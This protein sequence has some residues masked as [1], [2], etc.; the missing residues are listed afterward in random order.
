MSH[1]DGC[2]RMLSKIILMLC[3]IIRNLPN[4]GLGTIMKPNQT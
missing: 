2:L 3:S 4:I 1:F